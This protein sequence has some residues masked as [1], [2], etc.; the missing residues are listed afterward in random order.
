MSK[1]DEKIAKVS[2][3]KFQVSLDEKNIPVEL[4]WKADDS[5][6]NENKACKA[7]LI[8]VWDGET[9]NTLRID[10][11]TNKMEVNEM[12]HFFFQTLVTMADTF[13]KA[14]GNA[15]QSKKMAEFAQSFAK[16]LKLFPEK[17]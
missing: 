10:L 16:D 2:E 14:T 11:W 9:K 1:T 13:K 7:M 4:H 6:F 15:E 12:N 8:S 3:I 17:K 5:T